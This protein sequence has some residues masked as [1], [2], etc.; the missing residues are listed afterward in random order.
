MGDLVGDDF[1]NTLLRRDGRILRIEQQRRFVVGN[2]APILHGAPKS[3]RDR[4]LIELGQWIWNPKILIVIMQNLGRAFQG[5]AAALC[6]AFR[7]DDAQLD[8]FS[9]GFDRV[10]L[11]CAKDIQVG[12]H[13]RRRLETDFTSSAD[14][15]LTRDRHVGN[16]HP[17]FRHD[18]A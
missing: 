17:V 11:T 5:V 1:I 8:P 2:S 3:T 7:G 6:L 13:G 18:G 16:R 10:K 15:P 9:F 4:E 12:R 14:F